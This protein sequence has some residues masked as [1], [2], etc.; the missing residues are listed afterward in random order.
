MTDSE[1]EKSLIVDPKLSNLTGLFADVALSD[2]QE[3]QVYE[4][5]LISYI[6]LLNKVSFERNRDT[7][8]SQLMK[9][10]GKKAKGKY[11]RYMYTET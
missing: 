2:I 9:R 7:M 5:L 6:T 10:F 3:D 8:E 11:T 4:Q 1:L